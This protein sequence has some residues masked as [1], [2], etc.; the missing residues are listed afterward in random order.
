MN[1]HKP[2]YKKVRIL[3]PPEQRFIDSYA[4]GDTEVRFVEFPNIENDNYRYHVV[5]ETPE[6][7]DGY[8]GAELE[9]AQQQ[10]DAWVKELGG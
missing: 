7:E 8:W 3:P 1:K 4:N 2:K 10:Y 5:K 9:P 6:G